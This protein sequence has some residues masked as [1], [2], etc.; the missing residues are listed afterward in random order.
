MP[1]C[2]GGVLWFGVD[3]ATLNVRVP[4]YACTDRAPHAYAYGNGDAGHWAPR[5]AYWAFNVVANFAYGRWDVVGADVRH[6]VA[7]KEAELFG[8]VRA[9]DA[10]AEGA[11][12][13]GA[14]DAQLRAQLS[15]FS[16]TTAEGVVDSWISLFPQLFVRYRDYLV[17][18]PGGAPASPKDQP[19]PPSCTDVG[20]DTQWYDRLV[21]D[22]GDRYLVPPAPPA[23]RRHEERKL[24]LLRRVA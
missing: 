21:R 12:K 9:A 24:E 10:A 8:A 2:S 19:P 18:S 1:A 6:R 3:D 15:N 23:L 14:T 5:A 17:V 4:M 20:Y 7:A 16:V 13:A 11:A 22:T